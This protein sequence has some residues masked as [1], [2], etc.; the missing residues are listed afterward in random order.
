MKQTLPF[1]MA[2]IIAA[3][4]FACTGQ[5]EVQMSLTDVELVKIDTIQRYSE[6]GQ[7]LLTW[8]DENHV[9]YIT[10]VPLETYYPLGVR[11]KVMVKR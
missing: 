9:D 3:V 10:F 6:S 1:L 11:M 7:K 8:R 2:A 4:L 5:K